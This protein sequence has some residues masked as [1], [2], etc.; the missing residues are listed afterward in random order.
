MNVERLKERLERWLSP[1]YN[2][3]GGMMDYNRRTTDIITDKQIKEKA[4]NGRTTKELIA[5][6]SLQNEKAHGEMNTKL[7]IATVK[8]EWHDKFIMILIRVGIVLGSSIVLGVV[9]YSAT[10]VWEKLT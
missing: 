4:N 2:F 9:G 6:M 10:I 1:E 8:I 5:E 3:V 7:V